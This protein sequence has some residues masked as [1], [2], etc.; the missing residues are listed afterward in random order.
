ME[1]WREGRLE[2]REK[3]LEKGGVRG[4]R[5]RVKI[6]VAERFRRGFVESW[7]ERFG[8]KEAGDSCED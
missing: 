6:K 7:E 8:G 2:K 5:R 1:R 4:M 3:A